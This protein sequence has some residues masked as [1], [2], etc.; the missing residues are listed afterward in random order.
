MI[1]SV[2]FYFKMF[3][4]APSPLC[5]QL[6]EVYSS[7]IFLELYHFYFL[8]FGDKYIYHTNCYKLVYILYY[9]CDYQFFTIKNGSPITIIPLWSSLLFFTSYPILKSSYIRL[10]S[11]PGQLM[12]SYYILIL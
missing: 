8:P 3:P 9:P 12:N 11:R 10:L 2:R 4:L 7:L 1:D 5:L 6:V